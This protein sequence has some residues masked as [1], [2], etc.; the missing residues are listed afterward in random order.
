MSK[1]LVME[2]QQSLIQFPK[3]MR[4]NLKRL[5]FDKYYDAQEPKM[6]ES[7]CWAAPHKFLDGEKYEWTDPTL[8][9]EGS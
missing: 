9:R 4:D 3:P 8:E 1:E 2:K 6:R 5:K 7:D